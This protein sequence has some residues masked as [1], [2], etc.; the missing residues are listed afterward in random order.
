MIKKD[1]NELR[2]TLIAAVDP[3]RAY[4]LPYMLATMLT[5][6]LTQG[7]GTPQAG[8]ADIALPAP[9]TADGRVWA[10]RGDLAKRVGYTGNGL[11]RYLCQAEKSGKVRILQLKD[12][13]GK[14]PK[15]YNIADFEDFFAQKGTK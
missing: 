12:E 8:D 9:Q 3:N 2:N 10:T 7:F 4:D 11:D 6:A 13:F 5:E 1:K 14:G 15:L